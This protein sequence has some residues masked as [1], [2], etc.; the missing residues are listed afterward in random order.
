MTTIQDIVA[1]LREL[2]WLSPV[3]AEEMN[4]RDRWL[5]D[6]IEAVALPPA[7]PQGQELYEA[8]R[9]LRLVI[10]QLETIHERER[11]TT[12]TPIAWVSMTDEQKYEEYI[13]VRTL[14]T[15][16]VPLPPSP[17]EPEQ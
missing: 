11:V 7:P 14:F 15:P 3:S 9:Q 1:S 13:R 17:Q 16:P 12:F 2:T 4:R 10:R 5:A 6:T 8:I